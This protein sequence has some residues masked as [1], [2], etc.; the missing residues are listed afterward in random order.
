[1][2]QRAIDIVYRAPYLEYGNEEFPYDVLDALHILWDEPTFC[3]VIDRGPELNL[4][5]NIE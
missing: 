5:E 3:K 2:I 1:M 4:S